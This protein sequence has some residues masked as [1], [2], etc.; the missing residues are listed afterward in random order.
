MEWCIREDLNQTAPRYMAVLDPIKV[1][2]TNYPDDNQ[3]YMKAS[4][5]PEDPSAGER[6]IPFSKEL[7][8]ERDDFMEDP[9]KNSSGYAP[10][11]KFV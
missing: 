10:V 11:V 1:I 8:I 5:N 7:Y 3:E 6:S 2:L 9:P 4:I